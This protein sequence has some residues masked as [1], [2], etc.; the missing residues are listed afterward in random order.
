[1]NKKIDIT[2]PYLKT[3]TQNLSAG[4]RLIIP[5]VDRAELLSGLLNF[6][7]D[8]AAK[9]VQLLRYLLNSLNLENMVI[10]TVDEIFAA[11][12]LSKPFILGVLKSLEQ[13]HVI[14]RRSGVIKFNPV[15]LN[16]QLQVLIKLEAGN[17]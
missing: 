5:S 13:L 15:F 2:K 17:G 14:T 11:T 6:V 16:T 8:P 3:D 1:M 7:D 4:E 12:G 9:K 10:I